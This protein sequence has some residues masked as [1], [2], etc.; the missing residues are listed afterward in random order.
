MIYNLFSVSITTTKKSTKTQISLTFVLSL[1]QTTYSYIMLEGCLWTS[2]LTV[3]EP[4]SHLLCAGIGFS[5]LTVWVSNVKFKLIRSMQTFLYKFHLHFI[6]STAMLH[7][8]EHAVGFLFETLSFTPSWNAED[9]ELEI[10]C[11]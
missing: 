4:T 8:F 2:A 7:T 1:Y 5:S 9:Q 3:Q 10:N 11:K 6:V